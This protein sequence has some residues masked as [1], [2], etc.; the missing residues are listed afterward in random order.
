M[1]VYVGEHVLCMDVLWVV[2][3]G[4]GDGFLSMYVSLS[5][6]YACTI[7]CSPRRA[8]A[9]KVTV[10][11]S[12]FVRYSTSHLLNVCLSRNRYHI[13]NGQRRSEFSVFFSENAPL[14][15]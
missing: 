13:L 1:H 7:S 15:S 3:L 14:Q 11:G 12:V 4:C 2:Y 9:A 5:C 10:V 8:C 6:W